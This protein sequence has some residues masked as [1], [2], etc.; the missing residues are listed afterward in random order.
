M[1]SE[2]LRGEESV[3]AGEDDEH[4]IGTFY[5]FNETPE[6]MFISNEEED[7][8]VMA[9]FEDDY[10]VWYVHGKIEGTKQMD[11]EGKKIL[12][13]HQYPNHE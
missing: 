12:I 11:D 10:V 9:Q 13:A 7:G 5:W 3:Y 8:R 1:M 2:Y 4:F 6:E